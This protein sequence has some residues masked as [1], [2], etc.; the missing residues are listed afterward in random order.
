MKKNKITPESYSLLQKEVADLEKTR[1]EIAENLG[2]SAEICQKNNNKS[3]VGL[4]SVVTYKILTAGEEET[5]EITDT[6]E[7]SPPQKIS[8][9]SPV[10]ES[11][12]GKKV[13]K[14][15]IRQGMDLGLARMKL[16]CRL[17][18]RP[19][20]KQNTVHITGTNGKGKLE[21]KLQP[22]IFEF[23]TIVALYYFAEIK[24][25]D[26]VIYEVGLGGKYD[27]TNVIFPLVCGITNVAYDHAH[28][29]GNTLPSIAQEKAGIIKK[30]A[31]CFTTETRPQILSLFRK[32]AQK[33][34]SQLSKI[35][36][37]EKFTFASNE[38]MTSFCLTTKN[39]AFNLKTKMLGQHQIKNISLAVHMALYLQQYFPQITQINGA[40]N[41]AGIKSLIQA[42]KTFF[43]TKKPIFLVS[44]MKDK[45]V[46]KMLDALKKVACQIIFTEMPSSRRQEISQLKQRNTVK[47]RKI[48]DCSKA[49]FSFYSLLDSEKIGIITDKKA[50]NQEIIED[51][52]KHLENSSAV[53]FLEALND[54]VKKAELEMAIKRTKRISAK[55][56]LRLSSDGE[57]QKTQRGVSI[58][59]YVY[60]GG[61]GM[62]LKI[63][64]LVKT[65]AAVYENYGKDCYVVLLSPQG[66]RF[67]QRDVKRL[68][69]NKKLVFICGHYEGLDERILN[70]V[71]EQISVG[72]FITSGGEIPA[73]L[74]TETLIRALPGVLSN[75]VYQNETLLTENLFDFAT[76]TRPAIFEKQEVPAV[77]LSGNHQKI[78]EWRQENS[79]QKTQ[80]QGQ[81]FR[82]QQKI[83]PQT[84]R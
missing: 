51:G 61:P 67:T 84:D 9:Y 43:P 6:V 7:A 69:Q 44:I 22:T 34:Q 58:D 50:I 64:C 15:F 36:L 30:G 2:L 57:K 12:L 70:Y 80:R 47:F 74:I 23:V 42:I 40:H 17:L 27:A 46:N 55:T 8:L 53:Q 78:R 83:I 79:Q 54:P 48:V 45:P 1:G 39:Y 4:G 31:P 37:P 63:D 33:K 65:L 73:L 5:V 25:V 29:L 76:Y 71:D 21:S 49:F 56:S 41:Q 59:D 52:K 20:K 35:S 77:L 16:A 11:L 10:G 13:E 82:N 3:L 72:D 32:T 26:L 38:L 62:L 66:K 60:G 28:Y 18:N 24:P 19:E 81:N 75:E 14:Q 68:I